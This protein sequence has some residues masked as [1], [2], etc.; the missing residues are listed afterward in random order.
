MG[1]ELFVC[2]QVC[3]VRCFSCVLFVTVPDNRVTLYHVDNVFGGAVNVMINKSSFAGRINCILC[4][5][6]VSP[7][8]M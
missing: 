2:Q 8:F 6:L 4:V 1:L 5:Y 7:S 3:D